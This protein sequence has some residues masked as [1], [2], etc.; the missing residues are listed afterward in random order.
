[1]ASEEE[2]ADGRGLRQARGPHDAITDHALA[3]RPRCRRPMSGDICAVES[4]A[5]RP[6]RLTVMTSSWHQSPHAAEDTWCCSSGQTVEALRRLCRAPQCVGISMASL[7][8]RWAK[9][10]LQVVRAGVSRFRDRSLRPPRAP[11]RQRVADGP[12]DEAG[13]PSIGCGGSYTGVPPGRPSLAAAVMGVAC[14]LARARGLRA[15]GS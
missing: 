13:A 7:F 2:D 3:P 11:G 14:A 6:H 8:A 5:W 10:T 9:P 12:G 4:V 15:L 1:M